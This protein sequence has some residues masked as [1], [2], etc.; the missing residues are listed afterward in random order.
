MGYTAA[1]WADFGE[2]LAAVAGALTG[3]LFVAVSIKSDLLARSP[4]LASRAAQTLVLFMISVLAGLLLVAPQPR[5]ALG[6]E[7]LALAVV[8]GLIL[9]VLDRR[10]GRDGGG[11]GHD[12][13][14]NGRASGDRLA[15]YLEQYSPNL[16]T[17]LLVAVAAVTLMLKAG[18]GLYWLI[19]AMT[20]SLLGGV[21]SAWLFLVKLT[22]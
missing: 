17:T 12:P 11:A 21:T 10:A 2:A 7:L 18:G 9:V 5:V 19:P 8:S 1:A 13:A 4:S 15:R 16:V 20:A 22:G 3:L 6:A 14:D